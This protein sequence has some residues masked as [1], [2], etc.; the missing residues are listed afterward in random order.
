MPRISHFQYLE[1]CQLYLPRTVQADDIGSLQFHGLHLKKTLLERFGLP[2]DIVA[3]DIGNLSVSIP[4]TQLKNQP[5]K[6]V[7]DDVYILA[8]ARPQGKVDLEEDARIEQATK[9]EKLKSAEAVDNAASQVGAVAGDEGM[10]YLYT[11]MGS[12]DR[13][14]KQSY[15]GAIVSKVV[16]NVQIH[17]KNIH[18]RYEDGSSTPEVSYARRLEDKLK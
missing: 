14:G 15:M 5:V 2:V 8:R 11:V 4:W 10:L 12:A 6:I 7:I 3:G 1:V 9:Q 18:M 16:D 17:V 13:S